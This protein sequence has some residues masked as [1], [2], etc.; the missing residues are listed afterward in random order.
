MPRIWFN[1]L[2]SS[3]PSQRYQL[4]AKV[5]YAPHST[6][7][8]FVL[9]DGILSR[10]LRSETNNKLNAEPIREVNQLKHAHMALTL[11]KQSTEPVLSLVV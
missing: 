5:A 11:V 8:Q 9:Q 3:S 10:V 7:R 6:T 4:L 1:Y 2:R